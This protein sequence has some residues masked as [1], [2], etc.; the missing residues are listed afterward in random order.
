MMEIGLV[1]VLAGLCRVMIGLTGVVLFVILTV[2]ILH[3]GS[4][5]APKTNSL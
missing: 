1:K 5:V 4:K 2:R 3:P